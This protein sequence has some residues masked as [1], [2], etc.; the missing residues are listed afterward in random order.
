VKRLLVGVACVFVG[1]TVVAV[2]VTNAV[3]DWLERTERAELERLQ[4]RVPTEF[5]EHP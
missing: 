2:R 4:R 5:R 3:L 1:G